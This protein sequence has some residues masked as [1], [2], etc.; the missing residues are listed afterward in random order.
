ME[1]VN[2][3][4]MKNKQMKKNYDNTDKIPD[5]VMREAQKIVNQMND[6]VINAA[7]EIISK[8]MKQV[9]EQQD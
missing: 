3:V 9:K 7:V 1:E 6:N 5:E 2:E 8:T 4:I